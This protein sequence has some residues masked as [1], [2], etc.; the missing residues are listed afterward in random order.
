MERTLKDQVDPGARV[1]TTSNVLLPGTSAE[2]KTMNRYRSMTTL[3]QTANDYNIVTGQNIGNPLPNYNKK[4]M[5]P[6]QY[7]P[8]GIPTTTRNVL[9]SIAEKNMFK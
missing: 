5:H 6:A 4:M 8:V 2:Q 7:N 3:G 9:Q 1:L